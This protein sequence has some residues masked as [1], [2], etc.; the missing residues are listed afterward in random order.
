M[1]FVSVQSRSGSVLAEKLDVDGE[2]V[3]DLKKAFQKQFPKYYP[4]RQRLTIDKTVLYDK[5]SLEQHNI[6][7]NTVITFKDLGPQISWRNVFIV[8]YFGPLFI[9]PLFYCCQKLFYK[10]VVEHTPVQ[11]ICFL[12]IMIHFLKREFETICVHRFSNNSMPVKNIFKNSFHYWILSGV[13]MAYWIYRPGFA[14]GHIPAVTSTYSEVSNLLTHII[15]RNLRPAGTRVRKIPYGYGFNHVTCPNYFFETLGWVAICL[16]T[17]S[18]SSYIFTIVAFAQMY[19][20]AVKKRRNY[21][22][23]FGDAF[24]KQR[25]AIIPFLL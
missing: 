4:D 11:K 12:F 5:D 16:L 10:S 23:E 1:V 2:T 7:D 19:Q 22:K 18:I 6:K 13:N 15:L 21:I 14:S 24:P 8:E 20:W 25:T 9:H 3:L 17:G